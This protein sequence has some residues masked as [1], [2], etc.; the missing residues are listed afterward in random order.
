MEENRKNENKRR[1]KGGKRV[2]IAGDKR[3]KE[4]GEQKKSNR[5]KKVFWVWRFWP[6]GQSLQKC[7]KGGTNNG[8]LK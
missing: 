1:K 6:Y 3:S 5:R 7:R 4:S 8:V 2:E